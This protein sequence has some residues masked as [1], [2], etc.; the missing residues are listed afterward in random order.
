MLPVPLLLRAPVLYPFVRLIAHASY[1][2]QS[3]RPL[4]QVSFCYLNCT[5]VLFF[6]L[7]SFFYIYMY[8]CIFCVWL[9]SRFILLLCFALHL[10]LL[11]PP[12][13]TF[14]SEYPLER[15]RR[16]KKGH[17]V[18][19]EFLFLCFAVVVVGSLV[20]IM[21]FIIIV[22]VVVVYDA[23]KHWSFRCLFRV[24]LRCFAFSAQSH[25]TAYSPNLTSPHLRFRPTPPYHTTPN[26]LLFGR[27]LSR[28]CSLTL[29]Q[30]PLRPAA[31]AIKL[32]LF[33]VCLS[34]CLLFRHYSPFDLRCKI[35]VCVRV[36]FLVPA[37]VSSRF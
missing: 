5:T 11:S 26:S 1:K 16:A 21:H 32:I 12:F 18:L 29:T 4:F 22:A 34:A 13:V 14:Q 33:C 35:S 24:F 28:S 19:H 17:S 27:A 9:S 10:P 37:A 8:V 23:Y 7:T 6:L 31:A 15:R 25:C 3:A 36:L 2:K 30:L 20:A